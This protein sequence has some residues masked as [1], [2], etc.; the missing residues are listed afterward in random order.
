MD[1]AHPRSGHVWC[2]VSKPFV[3]E[4]LLSIQCS[5]NIPTSI[6]PVLQ[7]LKL[8][9]KSLGSAVINWMGY[10]T[11]CR[12]PDMTS[13][14]HIG[15][16]HVLW[17]LGG[18]L[19][20][21][22]ATNFS[23]IIYTFLVTSLILFMSFFCTGAFAVC[24]AKDL[25]RCHDSFIIFTKKGF[26]IVYSYCVRRSFIWR[27]DARCTLCL[28]TL[29]PWPLCSM[30]TLFGETPSSR[31]VFLWHWLL[32]V[33]NVYN[34]CLTTKTIKASFNIIKIDHWFLVLSFKT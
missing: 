10:L 33:K 18:I 28:W 8:P 11:Y 5:A 13:Q 12:I 25:N 16:W 15:D 4:I 19:S 31:R 17:V 20:S 32:F 27:H 9:I 6:R 14:T 7:C 29:C 26:G 34:I 24:V 1:H 22:K 23:T 21:V 2:P 3:L 30:G